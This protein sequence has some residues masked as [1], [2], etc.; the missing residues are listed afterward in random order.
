MKYRA[1]KVCRFSLLGKSSWRSIPTHPHTI[2]WEHQSNCCIVLQ[3]TLVSS[4]IT[5][6]VHS[7]AVDGSVVCVGFDRAEWRRLTREKSCTTK[8]KKVQ[9]LTLHDSPSKCSDPLQYSTEEVNTAHPSK[10]TAA[11]KAH[12][13][14]PTLER[15][16]PSQDTPMSTQRTSTIRPA[17]LQARSSNLLTLLIRSNQLC[18]STLTC[19]LLL[20]GHH[21]VDLLLLVPIS[22]LFKEPPSLR[23][24]H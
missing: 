20:C 10:R 14:P 6:S 11:P 23:V 21:P 17:H 8:T 7:D 13:R 18:Q 12:I 19:G 9:R 5:L 16:N 2:T 3:I 15:F 24:G 4:S 1:N 22:L